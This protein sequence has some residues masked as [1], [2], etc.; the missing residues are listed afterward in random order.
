MEHWKDPAASK[1]WLRSYEL[2]RHLV[3]QILKAS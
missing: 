1:K 3:A 2:Y